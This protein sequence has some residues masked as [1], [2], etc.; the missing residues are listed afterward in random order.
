[1]SEYNFGNLLNETGHIVL[2]F[3][4]EMHEMFQAA[5]ACKWYYF[6]F[7]Y[8]L[9]IYP[10]H[11]IAI[12]EIPNTDY[13]PPVLSWFARQCLWNQIRFFDFVKLL[14]DRTNDYGTIFA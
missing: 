8:I 9:N 3:K 7:D 2:E 14:G 6:D 5:L 11:K 12:Y 13:W 1:M 4:L 10:D